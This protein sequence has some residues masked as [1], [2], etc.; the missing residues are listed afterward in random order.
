M[1]MGDRTVKT[2]PITYFPAQALQ[3]RLMGCTA[4]D[5]EPMKGFNFSNVALLELC[6]KG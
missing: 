4:S 3:L 1:L 6:A 5:A 2:L